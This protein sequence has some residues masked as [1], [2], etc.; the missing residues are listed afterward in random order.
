MNFYRLGILVIFLIIFSATL[1][2]AQDLDL[3]I[4][5]DKSSVA[6]LSNGK[7]LMT[8]PDDGLWSIATGWKDNWSANW[9][10]AK[11]E[12]ISK[13]SEWTIVY[14][15]I[16]LP[17]GEWMLRD[18]YR[19]EA[20]KIK[21]IRRFEWKGKTAL[22][23]VTLSIRWKINSIE[24][25]AFLPGIIYYGNPSGERNGKDNVAWFH[26]KPGELALF[27]E[28][29]Y[30][31]P[32]SNVEW[33]EGSS[34]QGAAL[35]TVPSPVYGGNHFD[36]W[37]S[38]GVQ[39]NSDNTEL[40]SLSGPIAFNGKKS[41]AKALQSDSLVYG[42]TYMKVNPGA[43]IEKIFYVQAYPVTEKGTGFQKPMY[44][45]IDIFKPYSLEDLPSTE[46]II[47]AKFKFA[48]SRWMEGEKYAGFNMFPS[49]AKPRIVLGWAGQC[50]APGYALQL[51]ASDLKDESIW[52]MVQKSLDHICTTPFDNNGFP[53]VYNI[54]TDKWDSPDP[55]S[56]GQA[57]NN[58]ALAIK[59]GRKNK[60]VNTTKWEAFLKKA[61]D[62]LSTK[63]LESDWKP[64]NT[65]EA[66][67]ISPL[68]LSSQLF[69]NQQYKQAALKAVEYY[70]NRH[71][72]MDEPYWGGTLDAT[73]EDKEGAWGAFQGFLTAYE[74][75]KDAKYLKWAQHAG[76]V[77]LSYTV[78]WD[79]Q[80]PSGRLAD[81]QFKTRG[82][83]GV[84]AQNQH[85][86]VYGVLIAPS[87]YKLG[88]YTKQES[89]KKLAK[90]MFR[91][92]GQLIDPYGSQGEQIQETNFAQQ[93]DMNNVYKLRGG[94]S[95]SWTVFWIT[96]HFLHAAAQFKEMGVEF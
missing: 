59:A 17:E 47:K 11:I 19:K 82:W 42:D 58:I 39:V 73:C 69:K 15:K 43:I 22:D 66:F 64:V 32:F 45:S 57:M 87:V 83:T 5:D 62:V 86:D 23:K 31:M 38:L 33:K 46:E 6:I 21:C 44:T 75:T 55:V 90:V 28:H 53:V 2:I 63:I 96:A 88:D 68:I 49:F 65:A 77:T 84:S 72:N 74:L 76:D 7:S 92:C 50:E 71:V 25:K 79:I 52:P 16:V 41:I 4:S 36:Q 80:L 93:G 91:S 60:K 18:A 34:Y 94:Y 70:G 27:E 30:P 78:V 1:S 67:Y 37:W 9:S 29:R 13:E 56:E 24:T 14:G 61:A 95:E 20:D 10:H 48:K 51:L 85:L 35:H 40:V 54:E 3:K 12:K 89:L 81:H 26:G 8:S